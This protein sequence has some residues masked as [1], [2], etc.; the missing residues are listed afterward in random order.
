MH[1]GILVLASTSRSR[2]SML[3]A[4]GVP[5]ETVPA[6]V[7]E[8]TLRTSM[9]AEGFGAEEI[10]DALAEL[11]ACRVSGSRE[12]RLVLGA[13]QVLS[14]GGRIL[15]KPDSLDAARSQL[16]ALRGSE[17]VLISAAVLAKDSVPIWRC[18]AN[19][20]LRM[21]DF[22][23]DFLEEYLEREGDAVCKSVGAYRLEA[24]G[25]Q[26]F[27]TI[28]GDYFTIL[29]LPLLPLLRQLR[30]LGILTR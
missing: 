14:C 4:A 18:T 2:A 27:E 23:D 9:E 5:Y 20:A 26:L 15:S 17:H 16:K 13:D 10:A 11:K 25:C 30:E 22:S 28:S 19:A 6:S 21:R 24:M 7:D 1:G 29:G 8:V 3:T 12:G